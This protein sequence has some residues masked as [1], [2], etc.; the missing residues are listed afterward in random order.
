M[1]PMVLTFD[2]FC[3]A[4]KETAVFH[5]L[6]RGIGS[7]VSIM[8]TEEQTDMVASTAAVF[9]AR[10]PYKRLASDTSD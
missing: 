5:D 3:F 8:V 4:L 10:D 2:I 9:V 1:L 7:S 6:R